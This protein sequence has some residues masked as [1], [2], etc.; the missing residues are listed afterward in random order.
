[1]FSL[2]EYAMPRL[3]SS[4]TLVGAATLLACA[5]PAPHYERISARAW[6]FPIEGQLDSI[7][8]S[9]L[10][11]IVRVMQP[12]K[13]YRIRVISHDRAEVD[14]T[15][16]WVTVG[17]YDKKGRYFRPTFRPESSPTYAIVERVHGVWESNGFV[18]TTY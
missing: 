3:F 17:D 1:L 8:V 2:D 15:S 11:A 6:G 4:F 5:A 10:A 16:G 13:I 18:I 7:S 12:T 9:D 14:T